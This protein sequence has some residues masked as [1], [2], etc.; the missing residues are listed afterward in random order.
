MSRGIE[1]RNAELLL[2]LGWAARWRPSAAA[3]WVQAA[4]AGW[5]R[6]LGGQRWWVK[7]GG[8][9]MMLLLIIDADAVGCGGAAWPRNILVIGRILS[10]APIKTTAAAADNDDSD[11]DANDAAAAGDIMLIPL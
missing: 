2:L 7:R 8:G 6:R 9:L 1:E 10:L 4:A 5:W 11:D 3:F